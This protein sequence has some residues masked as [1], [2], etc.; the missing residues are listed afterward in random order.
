MLLNYA[1]AHTIGKSENNWNISRGV[2]LSTQTLV[3]V[4]YAK[5]V[6]VCVCLSSQTTA[7]NME[8]TRCVTKSAPQVHIK[9]DK[10][11]PQIYVDIYHQ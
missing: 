10:Y 9:F 2:F 5:C 1:T 8:S 7:L 6:C 11:L 4:F 3:P